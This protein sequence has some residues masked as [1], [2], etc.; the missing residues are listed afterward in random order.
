[1]DFLTAGD[2]WFARLWFERGLAGLYAVAFLSALRQFPALLGERGLLPVPEFLR[3]HRFREAPS[4][5]H[6]RYGDGWFRVVAGTGLMLAVAMALGA[7]ASSPL[8]VGT[9]VWLALYFLY[10]SIVNVGQAFYRFGWESMI[11]E[12]G[13]FAAFLG[14]TWMEPSM[15]PSLILRW[16]LFRVEVGAGLIKLRVG[17]VWLDR[18]ALYFHHETQPLPNPLSRGFHRLPRW[19]LRGGVG[20]SHAV[21]VA[22]PFGLFL[23][24]PVAGIAAALI[25]V[26][27]LLLIVAGNYAWLNWLTVVL[28]F[29]ALPDGWLAAVTP[30]APPAALAPRPLAW[31]IGLLGVTAGTVWLSIAPGRNLCSKRQRMNFC[32]NRWHLVN[33]YG[34]FGSVTQRRHEIVIEGTRAEVAGDAAAEWL[35]Y[36]FKGKPGRPDRT[37]PLVAPYHLRLDWLMWFLPFSVRETPRGIV[38]MREERW[39]RALIDKLL[40]GDRAVS[41]LLRSDPFSDDPPNFVRARYFHYRFTTPSERRETGAVWKRT[42]LGDYLPPTRLRSRK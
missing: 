21:Q 12:A 32:W 23:P 17:G 1:M 7:F 33:A 18:T 13:F 25:I 35:A 11:L 42:C 28:A 24:Q 38:V 2:G 31:E 3:H 15:L 9:M 41:R 6:W 4:L 30:A 34:A 5:F 22:V 19:M 29:V 10:L 36:E 39:F 20:F 37:P 16:M 26:H 27:Q 8:G 40:E 14:P